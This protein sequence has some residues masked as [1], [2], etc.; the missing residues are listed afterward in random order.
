MSKFEI[1]RNKGKPWDATEISEKY[2]IKYRLI[3]KI[4]HSSQLSLKVIKLILYIYCT[5]D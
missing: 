4:A 3:D 5:S 1:N 2:D